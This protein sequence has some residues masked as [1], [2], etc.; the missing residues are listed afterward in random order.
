MKKG[1]FVLSV[2]GL[3]AIS[4]CAQTRGHNE[5]TGAILGG[6]AGALV[7]GH[8][9]NF[10]VTIL[11]TLA[12]AMI[13]SEIGAQMDERDRYYAA[14]AYNRATNAKVGRVI[15]WRN[16]HNGHY[17]KVIVVR[18]SRTPRGE[19]CREFRNEVVIHG[20]VETIYSTACRRYDGT[21]EV[22]R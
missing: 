17:G 3:L 8:S 5:T 20:R 19:Y 14:R 9:N 21:W 2:A 6:V 12:G 18:D 22:I 15:V 11:G 10:G 16:P 13:G 4:G 7:T 1:I